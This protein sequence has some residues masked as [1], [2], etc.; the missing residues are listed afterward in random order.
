M[1]DS[2]RRRRLLRVALGL[3]VT[4]VILILVLVAKTLATSSYQVEPEAFTPLEV[5]EDQALAHLSEAVQLQTLNDDSG[6]F[7]AAAF[8]GLH[9]LL[10]RSY[11]KLHATLEREVVADYSLLY[12]WR[13]RDPEAKPILLLAHM[14][15]VPI[16]TPDKWTHEPFAGEIDEAAVWGRGSMDNKGGLIAIMEAVEA[17]LAAGIEPERDIY[18][19]FGHDEEGEGLGAQAIAA[20]LAERGVDAA[21]ALDEGV[22]FAVGLI[23]GVDAETPIA[24]IGVGEKGDVTFELSVETQ[25]GHSSSPPAETAIGILAKGLARIE[26]EQMPANLDGPFGDTLA[27]LG[28]EMRGP[29][30]YVSTNLW[31]LRPLVARFMASDPL[32]ASAVRTTT[33]IT[34]VEGGVKRNVLPTRAR[35]LVNHRLNAGD[36]IA[37]V[38]AHLRETMDD[39]RIEISVVIGKEVPPISDGESPEYT[40]VARALREAYGDDLLAV[41]SLCVAATD[42][43]YYVDVADQVFRISPY[44]MDKADVQRFH[45][46]DERLRRAD[47]AAMI[48][49]FG[50]VIQGAI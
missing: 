48:Q 33:A 49:F 32:T 27:Q 46:V 19:C 8:E 13:G 7:D 4:L 25:G 50:R 36:T 29:L 18:L 3:L 20:L 15:V 12:R 43:R 41:P 30:R 28:P 21:L 17:M 44:R 45:G 40:L 31:L 24:L 16:A 39:E 11:P 22:G 2:P 6:N 23:P 10:E 14:D 47:F 9:A 42:S 5:D 38:E 26:A 37:E 35:A 1:A 34:I